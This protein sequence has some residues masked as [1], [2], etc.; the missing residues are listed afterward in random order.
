MPYKA[1]AVIEKG[2][3]KYSS[4]AAAEFKVSRSAIDRRKQRITMHKKNADL[5]TRQCFTNVQKKLL[6]DKINYLSIKNI[7]PTSKIVKN[8]AEKLQQT[9]VKKNWT[10]QF[11]A[12]YKNQLKSVYLRNID[13]LKAVS[14]YK[15]LF[16]LFYSYVN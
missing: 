9:S 4:Y 15:L 5:Y 7:L 6:I 3:F 10:S 2:E 14:K 1:I 16:K 8:F 11:V 13:N 12:R